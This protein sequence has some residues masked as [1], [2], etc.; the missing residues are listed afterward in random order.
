MEQNVEEEG[1]KFVLRTHVDEFLDTETGEREILLSLNT[2]DNSLTFETKT[3]HLPLPSYADN[4]LFLFPHSLTYETSSPFSRREENEERANITVS[5]V[6]L[7]SSDVEEKDAE[8]KEME[9]RSQFRFIMRP[10]R[11][12]MWTMQLSIPETSVSVPLFNITRSPFTQSYSLHPPRRSSLSRSQHRHRHHFST[13]YLLSSLFSDTSPPLSTNEPFD[14]SDLL[15]SSAKFLRIQCRKDG[16]KGIVRVEG[17]S[18]AVV[19]KDTDCAAWEAEMERMRSLGAPNRRPSSR[20]SPRPAS[21]PTS[22]PTS[23]PSAKKRK[24]AVFNYFYRLSLFALL[25]GLPLFGLLSIIA[26]CL[27]TDEEEEGRIRLPD[28][29][30]EAVLIDIFVD[31]EEKDS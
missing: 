10:K 17:E 25:F 6:K 8:W 31:E 27:C 1:I 5:L 15:P 2:V 14:L 23:T 9:K 12:E 20:P 3:Y 26:S 7:L 19:E 4:S 29:D 13:L 21:R 30:S 11:K 28:D 24:G 16:R 22:T 18:D